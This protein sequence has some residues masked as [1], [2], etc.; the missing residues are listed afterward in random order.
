MTAY[1]GHYSIQLT[2]DCGATSNLIMNTASRIGLPVKPASQG[3]HQA[4]GKT[5]MNVAGETHIF[6]R[7]GWWSFQLV[8]LIV[9]ELD[10]DFLAGAPFMTLNDIAIRPSRHNKRD[11]DSHIWAEDGTC[12]PSKIHRTKSYL[13]RGP[14]RQAVILPGK[15]IELT[16]P[17]PPLLATT[18]LM[19]LMWTQTTY[20]PQQCIQSKSPTLQ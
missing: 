2:L 20:C 3:A 14:D 8:T 4:D 18:S 11:W 17:H 6:V 15:Y 5:P 19:P 7:G 9:H 12:G 13:L 10:M 1:Y 16:H